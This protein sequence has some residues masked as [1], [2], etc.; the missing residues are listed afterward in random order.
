MIG[1]IA[2]LTAIACAVLALLFAIWKHD[3]RAAAAVLGGGAL[4]AFSFWA[5]TASVDGLIRRFQAETGAK[6][7]G[8]PLVKFFT[9][10]AIVAV[11]AYGMIVRL[12]LDPVGVLAGVSS[13]AV[14]LAVEAVRDSR[15]RRFL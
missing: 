15:W 3:V 4:I 9:R 2:R 13:L 14:A 11:A 8:F 7:A 6:R 12:H 10:H 5:I 1:R